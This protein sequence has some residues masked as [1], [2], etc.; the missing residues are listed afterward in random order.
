LHN[1]SLN[2]QPELFEY[3]DEEIV[4][5]RQLLNSY[6]ISSKRKRQ[7][8]EHLYNDISRLE[9][10]IGRIKSNNEEYL[11]IKTIVEEKTSNVLTDGKVLL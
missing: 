6:H 3:I 11:K 2:H 1:H 10:V 7:E 9:T 5:S 4:G 8:A